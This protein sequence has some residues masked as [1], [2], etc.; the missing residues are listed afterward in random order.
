MNQLESL[1]HNDDLHKS[2]M[3][4]VSEIKG[5]ELTASKL[6]LQD[7]SF[8]KISELAKMSLPEL[9]S[10][11]KA[12]SVLGQIFQDQ[13]S[14]ADPEVFKRLPLWRK[15]LLLLEVALKRFGYQWSWQIHDIVEKDDH[16]EVYDPQGIQV[17]RSLSFCT[18]SGYSYSDLLLNTWRQLWR[19]AS[20]I[21]SN[22]LQEMQ[23]ILG[24]SKECFLSGVPVH[25]VQEIHAESGAV[26]RLFEVRFKKVAALYPSPRPIDSFPNAFL[27]A[28]RC[29]IVNT[30]ADAEKISFY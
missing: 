25:F 9:Q 11:Q 8:G 17:Y 18:T 22:M 30:G 13:L 24:G 29:R 12:Y 14:S 4:V 2:W 21:Q 23:E 26:S 3:D 28:S 10:L 1:G 5:L 19:R 27:V 16:F 7:L 20:S 15:D 6:G